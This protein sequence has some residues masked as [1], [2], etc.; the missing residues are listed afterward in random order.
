MKHRSDLP[1]NPDLSLLMLFGLSVLWGVL[2]SVV[3]WVLLS[4]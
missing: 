3:L 4:N 1:H 2:G